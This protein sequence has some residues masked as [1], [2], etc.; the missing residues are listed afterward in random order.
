MRRDCYLPSVTF[1]PPPRG[2]ASLVR[3]ACPSS[4]APSASA[5]RG[6]FHR[7]QSRR[8]LQ[9]PTTR[10]LKPRRPLCPDRRPPRVDV[11]KSS[12]VGT[13]SVTAGGE[14][15][16]SGGI[17]AGRRF[18]A[19]RALRNLRLPRVGHRDRRPA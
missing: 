1:L 13:R 9:A 17:L 15:G 14:I 12:F 4:R 8:R 7:N 19:R 3:V 18:V 6:H 16:S 2:F 11:A 5:P 10:V